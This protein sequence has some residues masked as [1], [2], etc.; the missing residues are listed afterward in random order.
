MFWIG[1]FFQLPLV[2]FALSAVGVLN[3]RQ[4]ARYWQAAVII[5]AVLAAT[6]TPTIDPVNMALVM[7]PMLA[8]YFLSILGAMV[9]GGGRSRRA[10]QAEPPAPAT[11][12]R[13]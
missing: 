12:S 4:L 1:I 13:P 5:I 2:V 11:S 6:I 10:E 3:A 9:A 8:L 7:A